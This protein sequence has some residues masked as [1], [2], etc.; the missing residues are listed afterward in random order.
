MFHSPVVSLFVKTIPPDLS[1]SRA[2][3]TAFWKPRFYTRR[4]AGWSGE[5]RE[6]R[7]G[8]VVFEKYSLRSS[9]L[10]LWGHDCGKRQ[11]GIAVVNH[12]FP[13]NY[14][15]KM[16][17]DCTKIYQENARKFLKLEQGGR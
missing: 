7:L 6:D 4:N 9:A 13:K 12:I 14:V 15:E 5:S 1:F 3:V 16:M 2:L 8:R 10:P 17:P 11:R